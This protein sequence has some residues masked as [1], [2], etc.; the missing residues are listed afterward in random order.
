M[1]KA[2][3]MDYE[4]AL[5]VVCLTLLIVIGVNAAIY[6]MVKGSGTVTQVDLMRRAFGRA[7]R[8]WSDEDEALKELSQRVA[9]LRQPSTDEEDHETAIEKHDEDMA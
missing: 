6:V 4:K 1:E 5:I 9:T 8:P 2:R 7:R 3:F